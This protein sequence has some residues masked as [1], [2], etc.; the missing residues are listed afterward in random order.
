LAGLVTRRAPV[1]IRGIKGGSF[2]ILSGHNRVRA[3]ELAGFKDV[4]V[5]SILRI[6]FHL[7]KIKMFKFD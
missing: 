4:P 3:A 1:I 2:E 5:I 7:L 6:R